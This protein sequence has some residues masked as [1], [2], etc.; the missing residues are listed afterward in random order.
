MLRRIQNHTMTEAADL[1][2]AHQASGSHATWSTKA[3]G[4]PSFKWRTEDETIEDAPAHYSWSQSFVK[5][6]GQ[7]ANRSSDTAEIRYLNLPSEALLLL[8]YGSHAAF[9]LEI[10]PET[11]VNAPEL[12][13]A[14]QDLREVRREAADEGIPEPSATAM[15]N[16]EHLLKGLYS[17][18]RRRFEVYPTPDAEIA[19]YAPGGYKRSVLVFCESE[20]GV[21]CMVNMNGE[22]RRARYESART[23][24]DGFVREALT[25]LDQVASQPR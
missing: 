4:L 17:T 24:P 12:R 9:D 15:E 7:I 3:V 6:L 23:L 2:Q 21:L 20:G 19:I 14:L 8:Q 1:D 18:S 5:Y 22:H 13:D 10:K 16:A 25:E 11:F